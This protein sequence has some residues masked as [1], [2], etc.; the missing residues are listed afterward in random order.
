MPFS[1]LRTRFSRFLMVA[2]KAQERIKVTADLR[3]AEAAAA[4]AK[5]QLNTAQAESAAL[6]QQL[7]ALQKRVA[8]AR[9]ASERANSERAASEQVPAQALALNP[10]AQFARRK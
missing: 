4:D 6:R 7:D 10:R 5:R 3:R 8:A 9:D 2:V 1:A